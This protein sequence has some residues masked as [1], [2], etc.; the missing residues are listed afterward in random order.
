M[1]IPTVIQIA[2]LAAGA[3]FCA[4]ACGNPCQDLSHFICNCQTNSTDQQSCTTQVDNQAKGQ[5]PT[6]KQQQCCSELQA[7]CTC[8]KLAAGDLAAC[9]LAENALSQTPPACPR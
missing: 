7:T 2:A 1:R 4:S 8:D 6:S 3:V 9:G 5:G